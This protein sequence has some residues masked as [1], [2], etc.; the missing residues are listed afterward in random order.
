MVR[1]Y[2]KQYAIIWI[3]AV[4][5]SMPLLAA[6]PLSSDTKQEKKGWSNKKLAYCVGPFLS[7]ALACRQSMPLTFLNPKL[8]LRKDIM[9]GKKDAMGKKIEAN[10][11]NLFMN[12]HFGRGIDE[13]EEFDKRHPH[14]FR[15]SLWAYG[16]TFASGMLGI[17]TLV[18][19]Y[20]TA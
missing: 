1:Q 11:D 10:L 16:T 18:K 14:L 12:M 3:G 9:D 5:F 19:A 13:L 17:V 2:H 7:V 8:V 4:L 15:D 20:R 6:S